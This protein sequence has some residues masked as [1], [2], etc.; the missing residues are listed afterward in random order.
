MISIVIPVKNEA[1]SLPIIY[2]ELLRVLRTLQEPY[3]MLFI[4]DGSTD[5]TK[6]VLESIA[7]KTKHVSVTHFRANFGKSA[8]LGYGLFRAKGN[9][10]ITLDADLQDN[11]SDIPSM[12]NK[13][14]E[15]Y[16]LVVGWRKHRRDSAGKRF[17]SYL[18]N[19][20]TRLLSGI[21][22]HDYNCGLKIMRRNVARQLHLHGELHRFIPILAAKLKYRVVEVPV[23]HRPRRFG[24]SKFGMERSWRAI[25]DLLTVLFLTHYEGKP[26]HFFGLYGFFLTLI[27]LV[28][29]AYVTYIRLTTGTT[30]H[31][32]PLLLAGILF[33]MIGIQLISIGLIA[34][35][36][37]TS[38]HRE[39]EYL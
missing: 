13:L 37:I 36:I 25:I 28:C 4:N 29:N 8:A 12:I 34:E 14:K 19:M 38:S 7:R 24:I 20:G 26:A 17:S 27:G 5:K 9:I 31:H 22:L 35:L 1:E 23:R 16:D 18:F 21:N 39:P 3:E 11:P 15:D 2:E 32:I 33:M 6:E 30:G 10:V